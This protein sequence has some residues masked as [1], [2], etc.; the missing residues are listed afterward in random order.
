MKQKH[1][2]IFK[3]PIFFIGVVAVA[4]NIFIEILSRGSVVDLLSYIG[5]SPLTFIFNTVIIMSTLSIALLFKKRLFSVSLISVVWIALGFANSFTLVSGNMPLTVCHI[6]NLGSAIKLS[7]IYMTVFEVALVIIGSISAVVG[8]IILWKKTPK[9]SINLKKSLLSVCALFAICS[10]IG[11]N[12]SAQTQ[13]FSDLQKAYEKYGFA[14]CFSYSVLN[15]GIEMPEDYSPEAVKKVLETIDIDDSE[16]E[17]KPNIIYVH[18]ES[19]FD[20]KTLTNVTFSVDPVPNFTKLKENYPSGYLEVP[21]VGGGTSNTEFEIMT[22]ISLSHFGIGEYPYLTLLAETSCESIMRNLSE[23]GYVS[24]AIH[25]YTGTFYQ[26]HKV[27]K[28]LGF[29]RFLSEEFMTVEERNELG[30]IKDKIFL[31][32]IRETLSSTEEPDFIYAMTIQA[33]GKYMSE[34]SEDGYAISSDL[35]TSDI[36]NQLEYYVSQINEVDDFIGELIREYESFE[37]PTVIVFFGDHL[38]ALK[39]QDEDVAVGDIYKTEY[40]T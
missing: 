6:V 2:S 20:V 26:R 39:L 10:L 7:S 21:T 14:Y 36:K 17:V 27:Y 11:L 32:Y 23:Y 33:H 12:T 29:D 9:S 3:H 15:I 19:F 34:E 40:I 5:S 37:E 38:P 22:G 1:D 31:K 35:E 4:L 13:D 18:L 25:S 16:A 30:W 28:N 24:T 8:G